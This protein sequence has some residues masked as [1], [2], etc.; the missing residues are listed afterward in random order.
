MNLTRPY[1]SSCPNES[2]TLLL[3]SGFWTL[4]FPRPFGRKY[5]VFLNWLQLLAFIFSSA[6]NVLRECIWISLDAALQSNKW[7]YTV[8]ALFFGGTLEKTQECLRELRATGTG[9]QVSNARAFKGF[10]SHFLHRL[11]VLA[12]IFCSF[13]EDGFQGNG[14]GSVVGCGLSFRHSFCAFSLTHSES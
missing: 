6:Q 4:R 10:L 1:P 3:K 13:C 9:S 11:S 14:I 2:P 12:S 5:F 7:M 8:R